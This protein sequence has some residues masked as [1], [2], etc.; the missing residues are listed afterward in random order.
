MKYFADSVDRSA[1]QLVWEPIGSVLRFTVEYGTSPTNLNKTRDVASTGI[2][3]QNINPDLTY[4]FQITPVDTPGNTIGTPSDI[5]TVDPST[6]S[7]AVVCIVE[8]IEL[9]TEKV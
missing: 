4:Y 5:I 9:F 7:Q 3:I 8:G 6:L 2:T 1:L